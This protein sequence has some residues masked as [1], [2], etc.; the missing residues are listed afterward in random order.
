MANAIA[1]GLDGD[2]IVQKAVDTFVANVTPLGVHATNFS[3]EVATKK[4]S[5]IS[6]PVAP[7]ADPAQSKS[8]GYTFQDADLNEV[9]IPLSNHEYVSLSLE[10]S[11]TANSPAV[12]LEQ[13]AVQKGFQL[14]KKVLQ[15]VWSVVTLA[16]YGAAAFT[17]LAANFDADN[18]VDIGEACDNADWPEPFRGLILNPSYYRALEKDNAV[19][20]SDAYGGS[21]PIRGGRIPNLHGFNLYKSNLIP[22]NG[23]NLVG[24][25]I[26]PAAIGVVMR[27]LI[28]NGDH[29]YAKL[30]VVEGDGGITLTE[31]M[32][33]DRTAG[34]WRHVLECNYGY[35]AILAGACKRLQ[36]A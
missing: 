32:W 3:S 35:A 26:N 17:N 19:Q 34:A 23:E 11:E 1:S 16:N 21:E 20:S 18:V 15:D 29:G 27:P 12:S 6:V 31:R 9:E 33:Y 24:F 10:D 28:P 14:A 36:S 5:K 7:A 30:E 13:F 4:G 25:A 8:G 2:I 22:A